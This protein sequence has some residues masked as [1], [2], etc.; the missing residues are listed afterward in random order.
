VLFDFRRV[1]T[2]HGSPLLDFIGVGTLAQIDMHPKTDIARCGR[3]T[4][5]L[6][7]RVW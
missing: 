1:D 3:L 5:S 6:A 2:G 4:S 7:C